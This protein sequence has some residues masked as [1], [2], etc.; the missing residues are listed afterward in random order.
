MN[1]AKNGS[2]TTLNPALETKRK[3]DLGCLFLTDTEVIPRQTLFFI[4]FKT[5]FIS[6]YFHRILLI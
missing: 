4:A 3:G 5:A 2:R 1:I 6:H